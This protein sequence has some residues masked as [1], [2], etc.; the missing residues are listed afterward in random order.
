MFNSLIYISSVS[1]HCFASELFSSAQNVLRFNAITL[2][3]TLTAPKSA[4]TARL[5]ST[6]DVPGEVWTI[7]PF[8]RIEDCK[9]ANSVSTAGLIFE[10]FM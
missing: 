3:G 7:H 5:H 9:K 1:L 4:Y 8:S 2:T 6:W 10:F